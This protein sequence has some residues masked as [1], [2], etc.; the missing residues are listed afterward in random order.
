[1][2]YNQY[3]ISASSLVLRGTFLLFRTSGLFYNS[4]SAAYNDYEWWIGN[5][6]WSVWIYRV[7]REQADWTLTHTSHKDTEQCTIEASLTLD[8]VTLTDS[9]IRWSPNEWPSVCREIPQCLPMR[10]SERL[11]SLH[12]EQ[13]ILWGIQTF[14]TRT[15]EGH[16]NLGQ[17][18]LPLGQE[19]TEFEAAILNIQ[20]LSNMT[21]W[22][23][24]K[25]SLI[26]TASTAQSIKQQVT[27]CCW[28]SIPDI[29]ERFF[30]TLQCLYRLWG[31]TSSYPVG[32]GTLS[33]G[34]KRTGSEADHSPPSR[35]EVKN[36]EAILPL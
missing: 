3:C 27:S 24:L 10:C 9:L 12:N 15:D 14:S 21:S 35:T 26:W 29:S 1:M 4:V 13:S 11:I 33:R 30:F 25:W 31:H 36:D 32:T 7:F 20:L 2:D 17:K 16:H 28:C 19:T 18:S 5:N 6:V 23:I 8:G 22:L 34:V